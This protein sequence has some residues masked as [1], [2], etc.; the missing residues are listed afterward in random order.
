[1]VYWM[2]IERFH[3]SLRLKSVSYVFVLV[4]VLEIKTHKIYSQQNVT[5]EWETVGC[6]WSSINVYLNRFDSIWHFNFYDQTFFHL[7]TKI[8]QILSLAL[9]YTFIFRCQ[10]S[11]ISTAISIELYFLANRKFSILLHRYGRCSQIQNNQLL[12]NDFM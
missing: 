11:N 12:G 3:Q 1:M 4:F 5:D 6:M 8:M 7:L 9:V 2:E 10:I